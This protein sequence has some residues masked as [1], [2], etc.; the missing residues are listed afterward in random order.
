MP[1][2]EKMKIYNIPDYDLKTIFIGNSAQSILAQVDIAQDLKDYVLLGAL[3]ELYR[4]DYQHFIYL[5]YVLPFGQVHCGCCTWSYPYSS[6]RA[7][8]A[9]PTHHFK[10]YFMISDSSIKPSIPTHLTRVID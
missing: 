5:P 3:M 8:L 2:N 10:A 7:T 4:H 9:L 1:M 6:A